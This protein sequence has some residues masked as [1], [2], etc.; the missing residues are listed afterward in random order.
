MQDIIIVVIAVIIA[1]VVASVV[2]HS[3]T[4]SKLTKDAES[5]IGLK[6]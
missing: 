4:V 5:K 6:S 1:L 2:T 3:V